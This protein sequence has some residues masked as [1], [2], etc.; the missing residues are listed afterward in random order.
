[1]PVLIFMGLPAHVAVGTMRLATLGMA[2]S[3]SEFLREKK[4]R[5]SLGLHFALISVIAGIV[6]PR[7]TLEIPA[8]YLEK[9]IGI[10]IIFVLL[11]MFFRKD[12]GVMCRSHTP[13][14]R[15]MIGTILYGV[16]ACVSVMVGGGAGIFTTAVLISCFGLTFLEAAGTRKIMIFILS[17][18]AIITYAFGG[19]INW[20]YGIVLFA[21]SVLGAHAGANYGLEKGEKWVRR[22]F[23]IVVIL[24]AIKLLV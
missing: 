4:V 21:G 2:T 10:F 6:G 23:M 9:L 24:S 11:Y 8:I 20:T 15:K 17:I 7:I 16:L 1:M 19:A 14:H 5:I 18:T 3:I 12:I 22:L 13:A